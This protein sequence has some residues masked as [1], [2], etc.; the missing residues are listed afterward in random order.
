MK[1]TDFGPEPYVTSIPCET[2]ENEHFR[3]ALWTG[4]HLQM[5][6][7][8]IPKNQEISTEL[9]EDTD[10]FIRVEKGKA[11]VK[12]GKCEQQLNYQ[13]TMC[14]GD[15]VFIPAGTWHNIINIGSDSLKISSIYAPSHHPRGT[16]QH[17]KEKIEP[18]C[19]KTNF[20]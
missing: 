20:Y 5:T 10:Q 13:H 1:Q 18:R 2:A 3:S 7:M 12:M 15:A 9:H 14:V 17:E 8:C 11:L 4:K 6:L 16:V 19:K